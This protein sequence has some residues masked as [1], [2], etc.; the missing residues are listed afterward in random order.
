MVQSRHI[1]RANT[2]DI[3]EFKQS[4][5]PRKLMLDDTDALKG[6]MIIATETNPDQSLMIINV[7]SV[8]DVSVIEID[9]NFH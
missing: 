8:Y 5:V 7:L 3:E 1:H 4:V 9:E 6:G 2:M